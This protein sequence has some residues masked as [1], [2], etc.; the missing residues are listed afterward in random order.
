MRETLLL[1]LLAAGIPAYQH[2]NCEGA[3]FGVKSYKN[4]RFMRPLDVLY[5]ILTGIKFRA[6]G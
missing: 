3:A 4:F 6:L 1:R 5:V 2:K